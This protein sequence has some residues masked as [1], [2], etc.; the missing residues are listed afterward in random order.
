M[1]DKDNHPCAGCIYYGRL[2]GTY[3]MPMCSHP[4]I[5]P[6]CIAAMLPPN[7]RHKLCKAHCN[8]VEAP[9]TNG[10]KELE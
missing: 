8:Y 9:V 5:K 4:Q 10:A 2:N 3:G 1:I 7:S 6:P